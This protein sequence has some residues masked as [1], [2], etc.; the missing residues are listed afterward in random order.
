VRQKLVPFVLGTLA[1]L[2]GGG[3][4]IGIASVD[5]IATSRA[6]DVLVERGVLCDDR[7]AVDVSFMFDRATVAPTRCELVRVSF[8]DAVE[9]P[10]GATVTLVNLGPTTV[11][12][13]VVRTFLSSDEAPAAR[14]GP[15]GALGVIEGVES[16]LYAIGRAAAEIASHRPIALALDRV[17]LVRGTSA[18]VTLESVATTGGAPLRITIARA[19]LAELTLPLGLAASGELRNIA[20]D[21]TP[22][23]AMLEGDLALGGRLPLLGSLGYDVHLVLSASALDTDHPHLELTTR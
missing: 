15:M 10:D 6:R 3:L 18:V 2:C 1:A 22:S 12:A 13:T 17:E 5:W 14:L 9:L 16:R 19:E 23:T 11:H 21:A 4:L 20:G 8:A 7:F